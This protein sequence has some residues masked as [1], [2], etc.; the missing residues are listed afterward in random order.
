[1]VRFRQ[2]ALD[3]IEIKSPFKALKLP[4]CGSEIFRKKE[5]L[6]DR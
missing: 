3:G 4:P 2:A 6:N 1:M 5:I